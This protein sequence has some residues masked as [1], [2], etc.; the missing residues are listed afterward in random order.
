M[1]DA[2]DLRREGDGADEGGLAGAPV[3]LRVDVA[4]QPVRVV[5]RDR[6]APEA[7]RHGRHSSKMDRADLQWPLAIS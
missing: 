4:R 7:T 6:R 1:A 5:A 3:V 2:K